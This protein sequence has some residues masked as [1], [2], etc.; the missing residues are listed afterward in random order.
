MLGAIAGDIIGS[1][2]QARPVKTTDFALFP[3]GAR[4]TDD[5]VLTVATGD[6][7][8]GI[9]GAVAEAFYGSVPP[10]IAE[11]A[12]ARLPAELLAVLEEF[13][14]RFGPAIRTAGS[15]H[16]LQPES[17]HQPSGSPRSSGR[18]IQRSVQWASASLSRHARLPGRKASSGRSGS[19]ARSSDASRPRKGRWPMRSVFADQ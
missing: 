13:E 15:D 16:W 14:R 6:A 9:A 4:F 5:S 12:R 17:T 2:Y 3:P 18:N 7:V 19:A 11:A 8:A 10:V 1:V